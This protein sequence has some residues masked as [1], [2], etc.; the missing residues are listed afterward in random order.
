MPEVRLLAAATD[1]LSGA[2]PVRGRT[3]NALSDLPGGRVPYYF[4]A[5]G[6]TARLGLEWSF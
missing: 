1:T 6:F 5:A 2:K 4:P 3:S